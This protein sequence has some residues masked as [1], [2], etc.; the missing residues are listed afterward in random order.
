MSRLVWYV[1]IGSAL[2]GAARFLLSAAIQ[3]K[4]GSSFPTGTL[5]VNVTGS[6]ILGVVIRY[7]LASPSFTP[8]L[9]AFLT[10]GF[11]GGYTTFSTFSFEA[12]GLLESGEYRRAATY[13][14]L[15][16]GLALLGTFG[17]FAVARE[18]IAFRTQ[19]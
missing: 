14:V 7:A 12:A 3:Q 5:I 6:F 18:M 9:R 8:E 17:G 13:M 16:V 15:S 10:A 2:G 11:C 1:A 4:T 19:A